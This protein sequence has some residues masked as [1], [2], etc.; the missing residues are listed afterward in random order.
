[1]APIIVVVVRGE[2]GRR[3]SELEE[4]IQKSS[5]LSMYSLNLHLR[6]DIFT[7]GANGTLLSA[8]NA[9]SRG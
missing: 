9:G 4:I 6:R 8:G 2:I 7:H 1:M 5:A 3:Y